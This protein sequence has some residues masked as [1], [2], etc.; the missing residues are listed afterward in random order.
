MNIPDTEQRTIL[1][2]DDSPNNIRILS[3]CLHH[4]YQII[5][6]TNGDDALERALTQAP[7]LILLD[8]MMPNMD[9]YEVCTKLKATPC[10]KETPIIFITSMD[11][12]E[13]ETAGLKLGA[14]DYITKPI[15]PHLVKL[16]VQ[17]HIELKLLRD[18]Y[19][20]MSVIDG[21]TGIPN[22]RRFEEFLDQ[23]WRRN[24]RFGSKLSLIMI[25]IDYFK[26]FNDHYGHIAGDDCLKQIA[27][28]LAEHISRSTDLI[29]RYGGEEFVCV[30]SETDSK[31]AELIGKKLCHQVASL[32]IPHAYSAVADHVTISLGSAAVI[33]STLE[34][35]KELIEAA[36]KNLYLAKAQGRNRLVC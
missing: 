25:D 30:L 12:E 4:E 1:I 14:I 26:L 16:R 36:D 6:A 19:K 31:G 33:P 34:S 15:N 21:L 8:I 5:F 11:R 7:D 18:H 3:E 9:G 20:H 29:A 2:V 28:T 27:N 22:R 10:T 23:E 24:M 32:N 35:P 13:N 17:N